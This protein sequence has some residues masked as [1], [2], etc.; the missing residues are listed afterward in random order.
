MCIRD[1]FGLS[2]IGVQWISSDWKGGW[3]KTPHDDAPV[4]VQFFQEFGNQHF[5][6]LGAVIPQCVSKGEDFLILRQDLTPVWSMVNGRIRAGMRW[7]RCGHPLENG[8][9]HRIN[10]PLHAFPSCMDVLEPC[11]SKYEKP[12]VHSIKN[13]DGNPSNEHHGGLL[14]G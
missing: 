10:D 4:R 12:C 7:Q 11:S 13:G 6:M 14:Y 1:R 9:S 3:S 2:R 8:C 5:M